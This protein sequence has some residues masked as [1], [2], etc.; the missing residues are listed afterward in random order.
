MTK[1]FKRGDVVSF[2]TVG[3][4]TYVQRKGKVVRTVDTGRGVRVEV[5]TEE[6]VFRP[7][8]SMVRAA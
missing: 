2:E 6:G 1:L 8:Q 4:G 7:H 3:R 5:K